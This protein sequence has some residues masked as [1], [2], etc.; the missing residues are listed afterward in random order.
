MNVIK[1]LQP[2]LGTS[3]TQPAHSPEKRGSGNWLSFDTESPNTDKNVILHKK[4]V[5]EDTRKLGA[6]KMVNVRRLID[7]T[8]KSL[9]GKIDTKQIQVKQIVRITS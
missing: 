3:P 1:A 5:S 8:E 7:H 4:R 6:R 9:S 2:L